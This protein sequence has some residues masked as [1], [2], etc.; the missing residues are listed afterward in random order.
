MSKP[1]FSEDDFKKLFKRRHKRPGDLF[2]SKLGAGE[3][4]VAP[5][6]YDAIGACIARMVSDAHVAQGKP[7]PFQAV[8]FGGWSVSAM[9]WHRPDMGF[10]DRSMMTLIAKYAVAEAF[11]LPVIADAETGFGPTITIGEMVREYHDIGVGLAHLEDQDP[12][13]RRCGNM[14]GKQCIPVEEMEDKIRAWLTVSEMMGTSMQ[15]MARTDALTASNGG[16]EDAIERGKRYMDVEYKGRRPLVLWADAMQDPAV[17]ERWVAEM[18][19]H[20]PKMILGINYSPN[21]DWT[22]GYRAKFRR[23]PPTYQD[24]YDNGN[25]FQLIWHTILQARAAM[26]AA[27][28][29]FDEMAEKGAEALWNL[30]DRQRTHPVGDSQGMS[31]A[32]IW[33]AFERFI[34]GDAAKERYERSAGYGSATREEKK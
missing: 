20:D 33:Q 11:P 21:K 29:T 6:V 13:T 31:N 23:E 12:G 16:L 4:M 2:A 24:L 22:D 15:L 9:L 34:G 1:S 14:G 32:P 5:G 26:E 28:N 10:H 3:R 18:R 30:H 8:Y 17:I 7:R 27:W 25:G 19:K